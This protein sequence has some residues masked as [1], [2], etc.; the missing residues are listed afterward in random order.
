MDVVNGPAALPG[1]NEAADKLFKLVR[2]GFRV[3][4]ARRVVTSVPVEGNQRLPICFGDHHLIEPQAVREQSRSLGEKCFWFVLACDAVDHRARKVKRALRQVRARGLELDDDLLGSDVNR[5]VENR[6]PGASL[7]A[8]NQHRPRTQGGSRRG[9]AQGVRRIRA[10]EINQRH[11]FALVAGRSEDL[12]DIGRT[13]M[14]E[15]AISIACEQPS[16]TL[17]RCGDAAIVLKNRNVH[18]LYPACA[19]VVDALPRA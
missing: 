3:D 14:D 9:V 4:A 18:E 10:D 11:A 2:G 19:I 17:N 8:W 6:A 5:D 7:K 1:A 16:I 12:A 15:F 13:A